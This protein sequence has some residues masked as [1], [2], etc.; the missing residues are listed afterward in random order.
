MPRIIKG[1]HVGYVGDSTMPVIREMPPSTCINSIQDFMGARQIGYGYQNPFTPRVAFDLE[2]CNSVSEQ[3][4]YNVCWG[5]LVDDV[6]V[7]HVLD[8]QNCYSAHHQTITFSWAGTGGGDTSLCPCYEFGRDR[9][10]G[11]LA[12]RS[13][14]VDLTLCC[15]DSGWLLCWK[16]CDYGCQAVAPLCDIPLI[17]N[18]GN[19]LLEHCCNCETGLTNGGGHINI[20]AAANCIPTVMARHIGYTESGQPIV[21]RINNCVYSDDAPCGCL[22]ATCGLVCEIIGLGDCSCMST[23]ILLG[24]SSLPNNTASWSGSYSAC[25][26]LTPMPITV[27]LTCNGGVEPGDSVNLQFDIQCGADNVGTG[28]ASVPACDMED[29][30]VSFTVAMSWSGE[31]GDPPCCEGTLQVRIT[32]AGNQTSPTAEPCDLNGGGMGGGGIA[33]LVPTL[34]RESL[35]SAETLVVSG[36]RNGPGTEL[37]AILSAFGINPSPSCDCHQKARAMDELGIEGC[38]ARRDEVVGWLREGWQRWGW[39]GP[40]ESVA[41]ESAETPGILARVGSALRGMRE[42]LR[43][44]WRLNPLD[45]LGSLVDEAIRRAEAKEAEN[46]DGGGSERGVLV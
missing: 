43:L 11:S 34:D 38:K 35:V 46:D 6:I 20:W 3:K 45:P 21:A 12:L 31:G 13:G 39:R 9:W 5:D 22:M 44:S 27:Q 36:P 15:T 40:L 7:A 23:T 16:G 1:R 42:A 25:G 33:G 28:G 14:T 30:D 41:R 19:I 24:G 8:V 4:H 26:E 32:R 2:C 10:T 17:L 18:F 29:L 37:K